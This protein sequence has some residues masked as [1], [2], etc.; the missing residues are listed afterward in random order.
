MSDVDYTDLP[1]DYVVDSREEAEKLLEENDVQSIEV[2]FGKWL[3]EHRRLIHD[4]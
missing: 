1:D 4:E 2:D 3:E